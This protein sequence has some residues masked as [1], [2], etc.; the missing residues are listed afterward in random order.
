MQH[1]LIKLLFRASLVCA[2]V[3]EISHWLTVGK[4]SSCTKNQNATILNKTKTKRTNTVMKKYS[5]S[6][7]TVRRSGGI[8]NPTTYADGS[9]LCRLFQLLSLWLLAAITV[10]TA[11]PRAIGG[12]RPYHFQAVRY[13]GDPAPGGGAFANDFEPT[14]L[15]NRGELAFTADL[16]VPGDEGQFEEGIFL[17]DGGTVQQ[18][19][20]HGQS[21]PGGG[22]FSVGELG[23]I[24]LNDAGDVAFAF[25][26]EPFDFG[27]PF[28]GG[29]YR[30]SARTQTL[31]PVM[32]PNVTPD[33]SGGV[34]VGVDFDV[35]LNYQGALVFTGWVTN[36]PA[37]VERGV[38]LQDKSGR[39]TSIMRPGDS[40][41]EGGTF[42][43]IQGAGINDAGNI[44]FTGKTLNIPHY[45]QAYIRS[46]STGATKLIP[47]SAN[48][49]G[50]DANGIN[51]RGDVVIGAFYA[52]SAPFGNGKVYLSDGATTTLVAAV[53]D[54]A[55]GGGNFSSITAAGVAA[56]NLAVNNR[57]NV[58]FDAATDAGDEAVYF[59]SKSTKQLRRLAGIGT[60][61]PGVGTIVSLEQGELICCPPAPI[62]GS[63]NSNIALNDHDQVAFAATVVNGDVARGVLLLGTP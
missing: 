3:L 14:A 39:I 19:V 1:K 25:S 26:L 46:F 9:G 40:A 16:A 27:T 55:P 62:T 33:P 56:G 6:N 36:T 45:H 21:A 54:P 29:V 32:I 15:N 13:I 52:T 43:R 48:V 24:G 44:T 58:A 38:F 22:T 37:G 34:F 35:S 4:I 50:A 12:D 10:G 11:A 28:H 5:T 17:A 42:L 8:L 30:W 60:V 47:Q 57:G 7:V 23:H 61:I 2:F 20:R 51:N 49:V 63:P 31:S 59:Y 18:I 53:G 41:P